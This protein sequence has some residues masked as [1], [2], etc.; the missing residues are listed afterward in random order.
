MNDES[1]ETNNDQKSEIRLSRFVALVG[2][3]WKKLVMLK[4]ALFNNDIHIYCLQA[5][6]H[7]SMINSFLI[8]YIS[9]NSIAY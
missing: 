7:V 5:P 3:V 9:D 4:L 2:A 6:A 8:E 1:G